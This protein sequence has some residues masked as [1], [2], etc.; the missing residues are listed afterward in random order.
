[1]NGAVNSTSAQQGAVG[2]VDD[3][4]YLQFGDIRFENAYGVHDSIPIF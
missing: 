4:V 1:M 3:A 2:G